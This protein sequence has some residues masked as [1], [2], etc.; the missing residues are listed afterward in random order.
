VPSAACTSAW[1]SITSVIGKSGKV[2]GVGVAPSVETGRP[3]AVQA[4]KPPLST[5][6]LG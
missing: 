1:V 3:A 5:L 6:I 2:A 4:L